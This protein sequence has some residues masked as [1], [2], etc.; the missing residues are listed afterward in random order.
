VRYFRRKD[1]SAESE[2]E[3]PR[4]LRCSFCGKSYNEVRKLIAGP[5][6]YICN[7]CIDICNEI[8][9]DD[10]VANIRQR[11]PAPLTE[12]G[13]GLEIVVRCS[14]CRLPAPATECLPV[15]GRGQI[16]APCLASIKLSAEGAGG[17][18]MTAG[19]QPL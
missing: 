10:A 8:I 12:I 3:R 5:T 18:R 2:V 4:D 19:G 7:E 14:L 16:C 9:A 6:V 13:G 1:Q 15:P 11:R 17:G